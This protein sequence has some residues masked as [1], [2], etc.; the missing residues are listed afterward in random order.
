MS[1]SSVGLN[2]KPKGRE[3]RVKT[4]IEGEKKKEKKKRLYWG[5]GGAKKIK[6]EGRKGE[7][8]EV[9]GAPAGE[10]LSLL[11]KSQKLRAER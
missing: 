3:L 2:R 10:I 9:I 1:S 5:G 4:A 7:A 6:K 8:Q 11:L